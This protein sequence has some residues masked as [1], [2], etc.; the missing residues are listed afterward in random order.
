MEGESHETT[1]ECNRARN[2][3]EVAPAE[4]QLA[5]SGEHSVADAQASHLGVEGGGE[6][7]APAHEIDGAHGG[8][9]KTDGQRVKGHIAESAAASLLSG[10]EQSAQEK[11]QEG[12]AADGKEVGASPGEQGHEEQ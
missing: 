8:E 5:H 4:K 7:T 10:G 9:A 12:C 11:P 1:H 3:R 6:R 2:N